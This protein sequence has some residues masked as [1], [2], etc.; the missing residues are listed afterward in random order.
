MDDDKVHRAPQL[1]EFYQSLMKREA[2]KDTTLLVSSTGGN[3]SDARSNMIGEIENR[4]TFL[5]AV[6]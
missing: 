4:S 5:L 6:C 3:A 2:K 1:V